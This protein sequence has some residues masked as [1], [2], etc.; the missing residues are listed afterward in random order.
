MN[1]PAAVRVPGRQGTAAWLDNRKDVVGSADIP[2]I[3]GSSPFRSTSILSL[4]AVKTRQVDDDQPAADDDTEERREDE[5]RFWFGHALEPVI[6]DRYELV[7]GARLRRV[8]DQLRHPVHGW[9]GASLDRIR[10]GQRRI[11]ELKWVPRGGWARGTTDPV[12]GHVL[13]QV[14]WQMLVK[15][16]DEADVAVLDGDRLRIEHVTADAGYQDDL[17]FLAHENLWRYVLSGDMPP[18]DGSEATRKALGSLA[19]RR[20]LVNG[21]HLDARRDREPELARMAQELRE[22]QATKK[23]AE[24]LVGSLKNAISALLLAADAS[25]VDGAGWR[26]DWHK[27][28]GS[29]KTVVDHAAIAGAYRSILAVALEHQDPTVRGTL[30][31]NGLDPDDPDVLDVI[32]GL[33]TTTVA[34]EGARSMRLWV[35]DEESG[36][37][38]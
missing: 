38:Q 25:G 19:D 6:A 9:V 1:V 33:H 26:I 14:Q 27:N 16:W 17:L 21:K 37:W 24:S 23:A 11:V 20:A 5:E 29:E 7:T 30:R 18:T 35:K 28:K 10:I 31:D 4:W 36:R 8:N 32:A 15:G 22:A 12:P 2:V 13:D 34:K 3:T